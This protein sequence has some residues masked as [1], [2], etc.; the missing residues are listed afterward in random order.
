[1][2]LRPL[3]PIAVLVAAPLLGAC[4]PSTPPSPSAAVPRAAAKAKGPAAADSAG[5]ATRKS[6]ATVDAIV[7]DLL[8]SQYP[9]GFD[10]AHQCWKTHYGQGDDAMPFCMQPLAPEVVTE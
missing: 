1:M 6:P 4:Q 10:T 8:R 2:T 9:E 7:A 5:E 3:L